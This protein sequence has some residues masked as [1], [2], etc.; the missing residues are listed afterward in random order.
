MISFL[1]R[2][3][4]NLD[5]VLFGIVSALFMFAI[6]WGDTKFTYVTIFFLILS[7]GIVYIRTK[8]IEAELEKEEESWK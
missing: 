7:V 2:L 5:C 1:L 3:S 4:F 8:H 6:Y